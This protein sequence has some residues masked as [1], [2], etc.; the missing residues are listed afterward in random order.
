MLT[1]NLKPIFAARG[2]E[3]PFSYMVKA[4]LSRIA[5]HRLLNGAT[6]SFQLRHMDTLCTILHCTPNDI[7]AWQPNGGQPSLPSNHPLQKLAPKPV[8]GSLQNLV[9]QLPLDELAKLMAAMQEAGKP[10]AMEK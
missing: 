4:G 10:T 1:I 5:A 3:R 2:I 9:K 8:P 6:L 7:L